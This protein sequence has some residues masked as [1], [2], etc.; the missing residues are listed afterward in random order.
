MGSK[1]YEMFS[2][3]SIFSTEA[4]GWK[5]IGLG[6]ERGRGMFSPR[7]PSA[8]SSATPLTWRR[9]RRRRRDTRAATSGSCVETPPCTGCATTCASS[10]WSRSPGSCR[11]PTRTRGRASQRTRQEYGRR[12]WLPDHVPGDLPSWRLSFQLLLL[13]WKPTGW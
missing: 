7:Y 2:A 5:G 11:S 1:Q 9:S 10:R 13:K 8:R 12:A 4:N 6:T 3:F